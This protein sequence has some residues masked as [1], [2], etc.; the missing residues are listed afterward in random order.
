MD[1]LPPP[2]L[3]AQAPAPVFECVRWSWS[4]DRK[5]VWC[6]KWREK[7]KPEPKKVAEAESD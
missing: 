4:S 2:P 3:T 6:L 7:N 5:E 1:V